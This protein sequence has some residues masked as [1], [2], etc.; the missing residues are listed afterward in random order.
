M[1]LLGVTN[2]A[3]SCFISQTSPAPGTVTQWLGTE[4]P[5]SIL[6]DKLSGHRHPTG[7]RDNGKQLLNALAS[8]RGHDPELGLSPVFATSKVWQ[9]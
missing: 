9:V 1:A 2:F 6:M 5:L 7:I 3:P 8:H 4:G